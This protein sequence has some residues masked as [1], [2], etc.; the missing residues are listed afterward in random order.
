M[1]QKDE[2]KAGA[3]MFPYA[4]EVVGLLGLVCTVLQAMVLGAWMRW[5]SVD[6]VGQHLYAYYLFT[7]NIEYGLWVFDV[8]DVNYYGSCTGDC[9]PDGVGTWKIE[10]EAKCGRAMLAADRV[11]ILFTGLRCSR[12]NRTPEL[13]YCRDVFETTIFARDSTWAALVFALIAGLGCLFEC[14]SRHRGSRNYPDKYKSM[15]FL[16]FSTLLWIGGAVSVGGTDRYEDEM[17][18]YHKEFPE[19]STP[20][21]EISP[22]LAICLEGCRLARAAGIIAILGGLVAMLLQ[23]YM[24]AKSCSGEEQTR[25]PA[26]QPPPQ[27]PPRSR[28]Y[29][30]P[31][32]FGAK[33]S[34][35]RRHENQEPE[36]PAAEAEEAVE[37]P[38]F[39]RKL[40]SFLFGEQ[41][42]VAD[43]EGVVVSIEP[44]AEGPA[45]EK[46]MYHRIAAWYDKPENAALRARWG[47]YPKLEEFQAWPG[48]VRV[49]NAFLDADV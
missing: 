44:K 25:A 36:A 30:T 47:P 21:G 46:E 8:Q 39:A 49:T 38:G 37:R 20:F 31:R 2:P 9:R 41:E 29:L 26:K 40:S 23:C 6:L 13:A 45:D 3:P 33:L 7:Y 19:G 42:P 27:L 32:T 35:I 12:N 48:F 5:A 43:S 28:T 17:G 1:R 16:G 18:E 22:K 34:T 11:C 10:D 14:V 24:C 15:V 4:F